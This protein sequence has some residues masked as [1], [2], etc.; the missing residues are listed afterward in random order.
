M[1]VRTYRAIYLFGTTPHDTLESLGVACDTAG[2]QLQGEGMSWLNG[3]DLVLTSE[4]SFSGPGT[5]VV[6]RC[7]GED[8]PTG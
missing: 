1:A 3:R 2:L 8:T 7:E 4:G 5:V 6:L